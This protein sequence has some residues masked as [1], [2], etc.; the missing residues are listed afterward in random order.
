MTA[1]LTELYESLARAT[2]ATNIDKEVVSDLEAMIEAAARDQVEW[3]GC[4]LV[5][6]RYVEL[7]AENPKRRLVV[8]AKRLVEGRPT[9]PLLTLRT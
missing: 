8:G 3:L 7:L 4:D 6:K 2:D 9:Q 1:L 5:W